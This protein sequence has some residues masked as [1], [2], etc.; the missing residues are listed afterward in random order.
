MFT[1][2]QKTFIGHGAIILFI[3]MLAG[4]G[5]LMS[6]I[7]GL[8]LI[9][10]SIISFTIPGDPATWAKIHVGGILN[11][12]M[13]LVVALLL[14]GLGFQNSAQL[15][16]GWLIVGTGWANTLFYWAAL[17]APN[18]ALTLGDNKFGPGNWASIIGLL[19]ALIFVVISLYVVGAIA[20]KALRKA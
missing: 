15:R 1:H 12:I 14:P 2:N 16:L 5:L 11:G 13:I 10:G 3:G 17:V 7:G 4:M 19:P 20:V 9:P 8:E 6:L 18:R